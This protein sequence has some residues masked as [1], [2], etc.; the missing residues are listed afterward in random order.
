MSVD[1]YKKLLLQILSEGTSILIITPIVHPDRADNY[2]DLII[3]YID[4]ELT[5]QEIKNCSG[6]PPCLIKSITQTIKKRKAS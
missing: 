1:T 4:K 2:L 5:L 6:Q 3:Q